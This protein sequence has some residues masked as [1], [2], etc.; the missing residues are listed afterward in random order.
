MAM[1]DA[2]TTKQMSRREQAEANLNGPQ[3]V[4]GAQREAYLALTDEQKRT[5][6]YHWFVCGRPAAICHRVATTGSF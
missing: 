5:Y 4:R 1:D 6:R 2:E 3:G